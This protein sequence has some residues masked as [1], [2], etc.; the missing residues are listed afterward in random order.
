MRGAEAEAKLELEFTK[1][2]KDKN[3]A[4]DD[5]GLLR[6]GFRSGFLKRELEALSPERQEEIKRLMDEEVKKIQEKDKER[7]QWSDRH[8]IDDEE[9][10]RRYYK[11]E[12]GR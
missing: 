6:V 1:D 7:Y 5:R 11:M 9:V 8:L 12:Y 3:I 2:C 4:A 10:Q